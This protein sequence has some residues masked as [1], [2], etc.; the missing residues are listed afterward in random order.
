M[1]KSVDGNKRTDILS[2]AF[3]RSVRGVV[4]VVR[5][6][7]G[8]VGNGIGVLVCVLVLE[9]CLVDVVGGRSMV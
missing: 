6:W 4:C 8:G 2:R 5:V 3:Q 9:S 7:W 1:S